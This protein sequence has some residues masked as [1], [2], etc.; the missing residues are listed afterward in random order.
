MSTDLTIAWPLPAGC[1]RVAVVV[2]PKPSALAYT[3]LL[4]DRAGEELARY[5]GRCGAHLWHIML[6]PAMRSHCAALGLAI[7]VVVTPFTPDP[8]V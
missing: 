1:T 5:V 3:V 4:L 8:H 2:R 6:L 7:D